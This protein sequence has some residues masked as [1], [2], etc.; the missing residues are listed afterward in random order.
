MLHLKTLERTYSPT[1]Q[2]HSSQTTPIPRLRPPPLPILDFG[3][4]TLDL[5]LWTLDPL[6]P[7]LHYTPENSLVKPPCSRCDRISKRGKGCPSV[8]ASPSLRS[9][10]FSPIRAGP[11]GSFAEL[12]LGRLQ[13]YPQPVFAAASARR[14]AV[15]QRAGNSVTWWR[16][17][18]HH[19][20]LRSAA[21]TRA[22]ERKFGQPVRRTGAIIFG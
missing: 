2:S 18:G 9:A 6:P 15:V 19:D 1:I 17:I 13:P 21:P 22:A 8:A 16:P 10:G 5:G 11:T 4:R 7:Y 14:R 20:V 12:T 3:S